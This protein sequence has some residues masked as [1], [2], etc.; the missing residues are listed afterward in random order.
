MASPSSPPPH[1]R[2]ISPSSLPPHKSPIAQYF[3]RKRS[4]RT[5][6]TTNDLPL[7][8]NAIGHWS[9]AGITFACVKLTVPLAY[10]YICLILWRELC[11]SLPEVLLESQFMGRYFPLG[12]WTAR[13]MRSS[14]PAVEAWA[15][16]EGIFY[17]ILVLHRCWLNS[18]DTLELSLR[19]APMLELR[20]RAALWELMMDSEEE[21][22]EF[23][24]GW[25]FGEKLEKLTG[26][27][28]MDFLTWSLFEGR[29][30]EHLTQEEMNQLR[31]FVTDLEYEISLELY[32]V[33]EE[34][35][36][37]KMANDDCDGDANDEVKEDAGLISPPSPQ[38]SHLMQNYGLQL[39]HSMEERIEEKIRLK[40]KGERPK[41]KEIFRFQDVRDESHHSF[42]SNLYESYTVWCEQYREMIENRTF[43][44]VQDIRD[45]IRYQEIRNFV[46]EK[47]QQYRSGG[48]D[49]PSA[50][51]AASESLGSMYENAYF[52]I[53]EK[54]GTMARRLAALG[55]ASRTRLDGAWNSAWR[56]T[57][58]LRTASD[59]SSR[60]T[61]LRNQLRGYRKTLAQMRGMA[62]AVPAERMADLMRKI[63]D[64]YE[65]LEGVEGSAKEAFVQ[66]T[67]YVGKN[68][69]PSGKEPP[70]YL[71]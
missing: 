65:A 23:I 3:N 58:R 22:S 29:N 63:T 31:G 24:T 45:L 50:V 10:V 52:A 59:I 18:L 41:P 16:V 11:F 12:V 5:Q 48:P 7:E 70:R 49:R 2:R 38:R 21:C 17:V 1:R 27:D 61:A 53:I 34:G 67:G 56:M 66:V 33:R 68:L 20:E 19:S 64:C 54:D 60:R 9:P 57:E 51:A 30:M 13:T 71:K 47:A 35:G 42:F 8:G 37:N 26:Y 44:S 32:G 15:V 25:F 36:E 14:S 46:A 40:R 39:S 43:Q 69:L 55:H 62:T 4:P 28:V 6:I